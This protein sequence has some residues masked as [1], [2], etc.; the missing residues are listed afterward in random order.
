M[1]S[2]KLA[3]NTLTAF[4]NQITMVVCAF[5]LPQMILKT[6]GSEVNGLIS[7][8][9]QF[10]AIISFL[11]LGL[12][13]VVQASL[14][15]PLA[16]Q[17][18]TTISKIIASANNFFRK[19]GCIMLIYVFILLLIYPHIASSNFSIW[20][21]DTLILSMCISYFAQYFFGLKNQLL[22]IA[23]QKGYIHYSLN[24]I[25][26][27]INNIVGVILII[28][29]SDIQFVK[30]STSLI[31][32]IRPLILEAYV[33]KNYNID[34]KI[35]YVGEPIKQK[36]NGVA[37][38][39][40]TVVLNSTDTIVLTIFSTLSNVSIYNV[41]YLVVNGLNNL[42]ISLTSGFQSLMGDMIYKNE[43]KLLNEFFN[44]FETFFHLGVTYLFSCVIILII[45]FVQVYTKEVN[46]INY[47]VPVFA[48]LISLANMIYCFRLPYNTL[49]K[50]AGHFKQTQNSAWIEM[51][52]NIVFSVIAVI[53]LGLIGVSI[54]TLVAMS[55][56]TIYLVVYL[57]HNIIDRN[58]VYFI[59]HMIVNCLCL[60]IIYCVGTL[61]SLKQLS[62]TSWIIMAIKVSFIN[63]VICI[64][65]NIIFF[66]K[67]IL[68]YKK[69]LRKIK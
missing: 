38:H 42:I 46:D 62:W 31:L 10:L 11:E 15:K 34:K 66:K 41:Y 30:L 61:I 57:T 43:K 4:I 48:I 25:T 20:Y 60:I 8:I 5:V 22:V 55:Y 39:V 40:A 7:S 21:T 37:Q 27:I 47:N 65:I 23:D 1:R 16:Q 24:T 36:W 32:L 3:L 64:A 33:R 17:D 2:R 49:I 51:V 35:K 53:K 6:F 54:G 29:G 52:I 69:I 19:L 50:S 58:I 13:A 67:D 18:N 68:D 59:K 12:G 56:R 63:A 28:C 14:Y 9:Q 26:L 45:P 44:I